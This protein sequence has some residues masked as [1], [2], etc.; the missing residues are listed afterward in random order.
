MIRI[1]HTADIH[2]GR[3]FPILRQRGKEYRKQLLITFEQI[4]KLAIDKRVSLVLIAGDLFDTNQVQ[5][6]VVGKVLSEFEKLEKENIRVCICPGTHD[7]YTEDSIYRFVRFPANVTVFTPDKEH[8]VFEDLDLT[9]YAKAFDGKQVGKSPLLGLSLVKESRFHVGMAHCSIKVEGLIEKDSM[10][11]DKKEIEV[12]GLDY[13]ALGHWHSFRDCSQG[14]TTAYYC[15]SPE[16]IYLDQKG[17]GSVALI[18]MGEKGDVKVDRI[19]VGSKKFDEMRIDLGLAKSVTDI[20]EMVEARGDP[21]LI[22]NVTLM[23]LC[24]MDLDLNPQEIED[25]LSDKFFNLRLLDNSHPKL[26][27]VQPGNFPEETVIGKFLRIMG[28]K[29]AEADGEERE[30]Y[31]N[32]LKLGF[33]LLHGRSQVIE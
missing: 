32:A 12:S 9:V 4:V 3:E 28:E 8:E 23:G 11:L 29:V 13:V 6:I 21:N 5:G 17:A 14:D 26:Q 10:I 25:E 20:F 33:A 16:P 7:C 22:L 15:G 2:L 30:L 24:S 1:L 18:N 31:E 27:D 19:H